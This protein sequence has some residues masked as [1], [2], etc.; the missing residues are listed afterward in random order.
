MG[1]TLEKSAAKRKFPV[2]PAPDLGERLY[3]PYTLWFKADLGKR[4][5]KRQLSSI[6]LLHEKIQT[7][8]ANL[9]SSSPPRNNPLVDLRFCAGQKE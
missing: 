7:E 8:P 1:V 6:L 2:A 9:T 3:S 5:A 4:A